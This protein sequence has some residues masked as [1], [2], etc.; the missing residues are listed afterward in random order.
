MKKILNKIILFISLFIQILTYARYYQGVIDGKT[1]NFKSSFLVEEDTVLDEGTIISQDLDDVTILVV[2]GAKLTIEPGRNI[3]KIVPKHQT[4]HETDNYK[5]GLTSNIV[6]IGPNTKVEIKSALIYVNCHFS[7][8]IMAL[9][10]AIIILK[11]TT[12]ITKSDYSKG[13]VVEYNSYADITDNTNIT[14]EG[15]SSP[16][17]EV[18]KNNEGIIGSNIF[19]FSKGLGSPL[20]NILGE[21]EVAIYV[22]NG[23]AENSQILINEDIN[24]VYL[25][26]CQFSCNVNTDDENPNLN[27]PLNKAGIVLYT[28]KEKTEK[29]TDLEVQD[30]ILK[31]E[32]AKIISCY[33]IVA[34]ITF[35]KTTTEFKEIFIQADKT[36][37][38]DLNTKVTLSLYNTNF[39]GK[40]IAHE[41][42][43]ISLI[44]DNN[45]LQNG[46]ETEG[47]V[48]FQ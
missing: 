32:N 29:I 3:S 19:L 5:Y 31:V 13:L 12:I 20:I 40:I 7:N 43:Q 35:E 45:I 34:D 9:N 24:T 39:K 30:C 21:G 38:S 28:K 1:F 15:N 25:G 22:G 11:N 44:V 47:K 41:D 14:T 18:Y 36:K 4:F 27:S 10:G 48:E 42:S 23:K 17:L 26:N 2:N 6:A 8:A 33:N 37:D 16:C 46:V